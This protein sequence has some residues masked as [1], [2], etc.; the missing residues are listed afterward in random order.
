MSMKYI[1]IVSSSTAD[2]ENE[3]NQ[4]IEEGYECLGGVQSNVAF[5]N[6]MFYEFY[7]SMIKADDSKPIHS[8]D[9]EIPEKHEPVAKYRVERK[10]SASKARK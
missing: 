10:I 8:A 1:V 3:V 9:W 5:V 6:G 4:K 2:L 7:Q